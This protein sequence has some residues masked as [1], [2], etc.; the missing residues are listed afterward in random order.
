MTIKL[1]APVRADGGT[2]GDGVDDGY[3]DPLGRCVTV[4]AGH[5][6]LVVDTKRGAAP[7]WI[8]VQVATGATVDDKGISWETALTIRADDDIEEAPADDRTEALLLGG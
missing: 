4:S 3:P 8:N 2:L 7:D 6:R 1:P 5:A